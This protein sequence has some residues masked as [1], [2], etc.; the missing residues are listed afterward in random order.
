M[1]TYLAD[2]LEKTKF[3]GSERDLETVTA[4]RHPVRLLEEK[5]FKEGAQPHE[6][7][8]EKGRKGQWKKPWWKKQGGRGSAEPASAKKEE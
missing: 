4:Y 6:E 2:P 8:Q 1:L 3:R 7:E 5:M